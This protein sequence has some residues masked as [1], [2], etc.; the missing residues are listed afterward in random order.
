MSGLATEPKALRGCR[1]YCPRCH[2]QSSHTGARARAIAAA[3]AGEKA[4][5]APRHGDIMPMSEILANAQSSFK[6]FGAGLY[7]LLP[8]SG[9]PYR[10]GKLTVMSNGVL[11]PGVT[12]AQVDSRR[13]LAVALIR[14]ERADEGWC[15]RCIE[16]NI[17]ER[18]P[19]HLSFDGDDPR[20]YCD[21]GFFAA[22][23]ADGE[24][25]SFI[26]WGPALRALGHDTTV[27]PRFHGE[28]A[29]GT[30]RGILKRRL[31]EKQ[32]APAP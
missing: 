6:F 29:E 18:L 7:A 15:R 11:A 31:R 30:H 10:R 23:N 13:A 26:E 24:E 22:D 4:K 2:T 25:Q 21:G 14:A 32:N 19:T 28:W 8:I 27:D 1:V 3:A 16:G 9:Q 20:L 17:T 5:V 12:Q